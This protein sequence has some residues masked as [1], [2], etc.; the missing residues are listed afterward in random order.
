MPISLSPT[1]RGM[2]E[3][4]RWIPLSVDF[5]SYS[6]M[7]KAVRTSL[8]SRRWL[9]KSQGGGF[10]RLTNGSCTLI[11]TSTNGEDQQLASNRMSSRS[12]AKKPV[13]KVFGCDYDASL[14]G[15]NS[16]VGLAI[17]LRVLLERRM[18]KKF[19]PFLRFCRLHLFRFFA[20]AT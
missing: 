5:S 3:V 9:E 7:P 10:T 13:R 11:G 4:F 17:S 18:Q 14:T 2:S 15:L 8:R 12:C 6:R 20:A 19:I 1:S 16:G